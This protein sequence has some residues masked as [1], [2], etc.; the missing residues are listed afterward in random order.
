[1]TSVGEHLLVAIRTAIFR[2]SHPFCL[3]VVAC[4]CV[5]CVSHVGGNGVITG[6]AYVQDVLFDVPIGGNFRPTGRF[7]AVAMRYRGVNLVH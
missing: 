7:E 3:A 6:D 4:S 2:S 5:L 1:M